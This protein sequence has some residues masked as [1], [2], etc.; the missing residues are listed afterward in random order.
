MA[1]SISDNR[2]LARFTGGVLGGLLL[3]ASPALW[4]E[5]G[6]PCTGSCSGGAAQAEDN[7]FSLAS[8]MG[9]DVPFTIG[10]WTQLGYHSNSDGI[11]NTSPEE[12]NL[13]EQWLYAER[14]ADG[15]CGWDFGFRI[16]AIYGVDAQNTQAFGEP[17]PQHH[18]DTE[19]DYGIHG[20]ALPQVYVEVANGDWSVKAGHFLTLIGYESVPAPG[21]FF[22]S[23]PFTFNFN[24]PFTHTGVLGAYT[25][26]D[27][28]TLYGGWTAGWDTGFGRFDGGNNFL[29]GV[30]VGVND[31]LTVTYAL[32]AGD[33]G[34][35]QGEG[36]SHSLVVD[37][38]LAEDWNY[39]F[40]WDL[41]AANTDPSL[42]PDTDF[43]YALN[44]YLFYTINNALKAG[45]RAEWFSSGGHSV[46]EITTG[47]NVRPIPNLIIRPE[48]RWQ[49]ADSDQ[50]KQ[51]YANQ[52]AGG[53]AAGGGIPTGGTIFGIDLI[54][55]Y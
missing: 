44:N 15:R 34:F 29:G 16:D 1:I 17:P 8:L 39:V 13:H 6:C 53:I 21:N 55:T 49:F 43:R 38:T 40:Q 22:Y 24:E 30:K 36:Y 3:A 47:V 46:Y 20:W 19:W 32:T 27:A 45:V 42:G 33:L 26:S 18:F 11:F 25:L 41:L 54:F 23:R 14:V 51:Y 7:V 35:P 2:I 5:G 31:N 48:F 28:V 9:D 52:F 37:A 50:D 12:I 10:G 4:A